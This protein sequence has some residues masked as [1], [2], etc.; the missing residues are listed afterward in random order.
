M[1]K[2]DK[3]SADQEKE[4]IGESVSKKF[5][6]NPALYIGSVLVLVLVVVTFV[7]GDLLSGGGFGGGRGDL[8]FGYYDKS[9][10]SWVPGNMFSQYVERVVQYYRSQGVD[11]NDIRFESQVWRQAFDA[12]VVHTAILRIM[13]KSKYIVPDRT[14][15]RNVAKLPNFQDNG[16]FS[17]ALYRQMSDAQRSS[18][19]RQTQDDLTKMAFYSDLFGTII[20]S[21]EAEFIADMAS[22]TRS[23]DVVSFKVDDYPASE[24]T[25]FA[26][27]NAQLFNSI[28]LSRI[29]INSEREAQRI[30]AIIKDGTMLFE[31]A[32]R[33]QS[34]DAYADRGGDMGSRLFYELDQEIPDVSAREAIF[35]LEKGTLS[36]IIKNG[37]EWS[38]YRIEEEKTEADFEDEAVMERVKS[39]IR[40]FRRGLMED[41]AFTQAQ[42]FIEEAKLSGFDNAAR[43]R[44]LDKQSFGPLPINFGGLD[45]FTTL[46]SFTI[47]GLTSQDLGGIARNDNFWKTA[48]STELNT[49]TEPLVQGNNVLV[50]LPTEESK[51]DEGS[52][53]NISSMYSSYW[54][55]SITEQS[56]NSYFLNNEKMEDNFWDVY[57]RVFQH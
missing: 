53:E 26:R 44:F 27:D 55:N 34:Q 22:A 31:D 19:W 15:D 51:A 30:L 36:D 33:S 43:S 12:A 52:V 56:L 9:P 29:S 24:Y 35:S 1:A 13:D 8:T 20:S 40:S 17:Q 25:A 11:A 14:V 23:F 18:L 3:K 42:G 6:Q 38:F 45:L 46:E 21:S 32:A 37:G 16:R 50:F 4:S 7:G 49:P 54:V 48:F 47:P 10:I 41:W 28:H 5:R 2:K 39:Y 57:F